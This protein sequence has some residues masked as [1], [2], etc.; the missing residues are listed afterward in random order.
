MKLAKDA[1][2][3]KK[4]VRNDGHKLKNGKTGMPHYQT[5]SG[6]GSH[7]FYKV[8]SVLAGINLGE[9]IG[10]LNPLHGGT[11]LGYGQ[12]FGNEGE[13]IDQDGIPDIDDVIDN[14]ID[15]ETGDIIDPE[16]GE[17]VGN[18]NDDQNQDDQSQNNT[19][20]QQDEKNEL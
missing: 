18:V 16:S 3:G 6:D 10:E 7:V 1:R 20:N 9:L 14:R 4:I 11:G 13:D 19:E 15:P 2:K 8:L 17:V 5:A 12:G